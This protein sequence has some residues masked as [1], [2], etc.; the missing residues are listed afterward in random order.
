MMMEVSSFQL[1]ACER[2]YSNINRAIETIPS[3]LSQATKEQ[4]DFKL[5][6]QAVLCASSV[7]G[8]IPLKS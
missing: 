2:A 6:I 7:R 4:I 8:S 3:L 5:V 1:G